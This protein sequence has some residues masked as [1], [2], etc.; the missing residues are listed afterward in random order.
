MHQLPVKTTMITYIT[1]DKR[2]AGGAATKSAFLHPLLLLLLCYTDFALLCATFQLPVMT[3]TDTYI[4][5]NER[6]AGSA[7][8]KSAFFHPLLLFLLQDV[9][10]KVLKA[11]LKRLS[12]PVPGLRPLQS[13]TGIWSLCAP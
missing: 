9:A 1:H 13:L 10:V 5:H 11:S 4:T 7:A 3:A 8:T 12:N 6:H 2:H